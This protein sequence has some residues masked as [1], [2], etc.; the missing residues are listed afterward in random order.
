M[1]E[2][3]HYAVEDELY[4]TTTYPFLVNPEPQNSKPSMNKKLW[5]W[6][7]DVFGR[8]TKP[9]ETLSAGFGRFRVQGCMLPFWNKPRKIILFMV[10][11]TNIWALLLR[12]AIPNPESRRNQAGAV[13]RDKLRHAD[14]I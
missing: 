9:R 5:L 4:P 6:R 3:P 7:L 13:K 11:G 12:V 8:P 2:G 1:W 10:L 14:V